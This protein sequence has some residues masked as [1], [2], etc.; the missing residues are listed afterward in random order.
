M[1]LAPLGI[2]SGSIRENSVAVA[3]DK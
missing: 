3:N 2:Y 1:L